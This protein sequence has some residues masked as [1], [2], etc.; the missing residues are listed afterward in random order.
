MWGAVKY[1]LGNLANPSGRDA[2]QTFWYWVLAV[3]VVRYAAGMAVSFPMTMKIMNMTMQSIASGKPEAVDAMQ[4][5]MIALIAED[6]SRM[7][8]IGVAIGVVSML[9]LVCSV[10]RRLHDSNL[11]GW[12]VLVPGALYGIALA[13]APR[14]IEASIAMLKSMKPGATP[15]M[16]QMMQA[17]SGLG[18]LSWVAIALVIWIGVRD[19]DD[20]PN[21][22]GDAPVRF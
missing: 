14:Q 7:V 16:S 19:S 10:V 18:L 2:R 5:Q 6:L 22:Y 20:E 15:D 21:R 8:W 13:Q 1:A 9:L 17:Q 12:L 4:S 11:S 3:F